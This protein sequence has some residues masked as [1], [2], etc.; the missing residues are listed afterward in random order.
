MT[1]SLF[2]PSLSG[3]P[4]QADGK[5]GSSQRKCSGMGRSF[6]EQGELLNLQFARAMPITSKN[7]SRY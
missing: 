4:L 2:R 1:S 5:P 7:V 6:L 3:V